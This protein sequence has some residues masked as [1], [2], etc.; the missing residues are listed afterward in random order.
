MKSAL[1]MLSVLV[2]SAW[3][4]TAS[5]AAGPDIVLADFEGR[6]YGDW[7]TT[8][9]AFG[10]GPAQ[11]TLPGQMAVSGY[12]GHGLVNSF[13]RG[14]RSTGTLTSPEFKIE[15][16]Y[17][18]F[19]IGGGGVP[20]KTC[21]NL[22][23]DGKSSAPRPART[24][25]PAAANAGAGSWD[26]GELAGKTARHPDRRHGHRRLGAHQRRPDRSDRPAQPPVTAEAV[27]ASGA[28]DRQRYLH[29][30][31]KNG[32]RKRPG[33]ALLLSWMAMTVREFEIELA[34]ASPTGGR[35]PDMWP[36]GTGKTATRAGR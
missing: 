10:P 25:G 20:G 1:V 7:K 9:E 14:D 26:V 24:P 5:R 36:P 8:G 17:I 31:V 32:L 28:D 3:T 19:L 34:D 12:H 11:G 6:D 16:R 2:I 15:R 4:S 35:A 13:Y 21:M 22:L 18:T 29:F 33:D 23:V 30:P 27:R